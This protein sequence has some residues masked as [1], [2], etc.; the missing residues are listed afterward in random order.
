MGTGKSTG[1]ETE[2]GQLKARLYDA[3][4]NV[5]IT[6]AALKVA[7]TQL[8]T[9]PATL[10]GKSW[11]EIAQ[12]TIGDNKDR[13]VSAVCRKL[14]KS[15]Q[16]YRQGHRAR[17]RRQVDQATIISEV[18]RIRAE[19]PRTGGRKLLA[20]MKP[21][22]GAKGIRCG[23]DRLFD[24]LRDADLLLARRKPRFPHTTKFDPSLGVSPNL[25]KD[26]LVS[27]PNVVLVADV[28]YL[29]VGGGFLYLALIMDKG[30]RDIVGW[31][32]GEHCDARC[33]IEA[34]KMAVRTLPKGVTPIHHSDRGNTY[35]CHAYR[36]MLDA[37][38]WRQSMT[39]V[40]HCYENSVAERLNGI[41][42]Q[43][44]YLDQVFANRAI[45]LKAVR[46]AVRLYNTRRL[47]EAL[48]YVTPHEFRL[49][50]AA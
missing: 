10:K 12:E 28:T 34:L 1:F 16:A 42:K 45:A 18:F 20:E 44:F 6:E 2:V 32:L 3:L 43:E 9:D 35:A 50:N 4:L 15:R 46:E 27:R 13:V 38:G 29:H 30:S 37:L 26:M 31:H 21:I 39:E 8:G 36:A 11:L 25:V 23:R 33:C 17:M 40:L 7:C 41:L 49:R 5:R 48:G 22:L 47:H 14:G 19:L 24:I